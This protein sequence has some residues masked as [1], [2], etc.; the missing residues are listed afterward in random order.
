MSKSRGKKVLIT[1]AAS[2]I[3]RCTAEEFAR[4]GYD[5]VL[6]DINQPALDEVAEQMRG[7]GV[8]VHTCVCDVSKQREVQ[9]MA[10]GVLAEVGAIDI[11]INN[12]GVGHTGELVDTS[13]KTWRTLIDV[14]LWGPIYHVY[15]FLPH[16]QERGSGQIVNVSSGQAFFRLPTWGAY[17][18]VKA[19]LGVFSEVLHY[20]LRKY[21]IRVTTVYPF[22]VNTPFYRNITGDTWAAKLSM[23]LVPYYSMKPETVARIIFKAV[24]HK[25]KVETV[26]VINDV[27]FYVQAIPF[28]PAIIAATTN[29]VLGKRPGHGAAE[30]SA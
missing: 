15:A 25:R 14:N 23:K 5:L 13:L 18:A 12:A 26:S 4:A 1:G 19:A 11:L 9:E 2:G 3:G 28:A 7:H 27:A 29:F 21:G 6:T 20:E 16:M 30:R 17:A 10:R 24:K 22:M 8:Q